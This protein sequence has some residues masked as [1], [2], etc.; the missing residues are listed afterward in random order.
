M[1]LGKALTVTVTV[2]WEQ[3]R[4]ES[5]EKKVPTA[6]PSVILKTDLLLS[7]TQFR[8]ISGVIAFLFNSLSPE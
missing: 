3:G 1:F 7:G 4:G 6:K 2:I 8:L 5:V